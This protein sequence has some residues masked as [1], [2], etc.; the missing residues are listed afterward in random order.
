VTGE[1]NSPGVRDSLVATLVGGIAVLLWSLL[2]FLTVAAGD[3]PPFQLLAM[4]FSIAFVAM[5]AVLLRRGLSALSVLQQ[6]WQAWAL[7]VGA[8][9]GYHAFYFVAL[10]NAPPVEASL[11]AFLWPLLLVLFSALAPGGQLRWFH[12][13][14][15][16]LGFAGAVLLVSGGML[17]FKTQFWPGYLA[18]FVCALIWSGYSVANRRFGRVPSAVVGGYCGVV[19]VLGYFFHLVF[20][21]TVFPT[22]GLQWLAVLG[23]G[24]GPVGLAFFVWDYGTKRG[25]LPV[26][27]ALSYG[28]PLFST[29]LLIAFGRAQGTWVVGVACLLIVA[30][31]LLAAQELLLRRKAAVAAPPPANGK[32][33][34]PPA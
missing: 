13:A 20:E 34:A 32:T 25:S 33:Q 26:L 8:L 22:D 7:G 10:Q 14:G 23:L 9:F 21:K 18:A 15:A 29:L 19:A 28:A 17:A 31:A 30:G 6:P 16:L 5:M 27:G 12:V 2:A 1:S 4:T 11:I 24:L 3:I